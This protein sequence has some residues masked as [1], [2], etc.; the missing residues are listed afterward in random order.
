MNKR[1]GR[2]VPTLLS[3]AILLVLANAATAQEANPP[4]DAQ[5]QTPAATPARAKNLGPVVVTG[6]RAGNRT[7]SSSLTPIDVI[8]ADVLKQT[9]TI[10]LTQALERAIPSLNFPFAPASDTF[11]FQRPF[12][13]RGLSPDQV[14]VLVDGK[15]WHPGALVLS[16]GQIGQGSQGID[17]NTI[18]LSAIDHIEVL[19]DG[20][21]AQYGSDA[22]SGVV[23]IILKKGAKGGDVQLSGG[24]F[25]AGDGRQWQGAANFG[26]PLGGDSGWLRITAEDSNQS[27]SNRAGVDRRPGLAQLGVKFH[28]GTVSF[29]NK[30][31]FLNTQ[32]DITPGVQFYAFGHYGRRVGEPRGFYRYG[33]NTAYPNNPLI[34]LVYPDG[35]LPREHGDSMDTSL[36]AGLRGTWNG[37]RWD[38]SGNYGGNRVSYSTRNSTNYAMLN[39]FGSSPTSFHDGILTAKQQTFDIDISK[40]IAFGWLPNPLTLSFGTQ[41]LRQSY[42]VEAGDFGSYY[43]GT[44]GVRG[45]A[46]GF[47]GWGPQDAISVARHD[48]AEYLQLEGNLTDRFGFSAALRHEDYSDF[49]TTT[50]A[51]LSGRFDFTDSFAL[52]GSAST[53]FR[54]PGLGQQH[55]SETTSAAYGTGNSLGLPPGIYLRGLVPV[56]NPLARLLGS[57]PL[58]A[59]KSRN[60]TAG[61]VWNPTNALNLS[62]DV[63]QI[64]VTNRIALSSS[65]SL[66]TPS[67]VAYLAANGVTNLQYSGLSYFTNAGTVRTQGAD[68]VAS[69]RSDFGDNGSLMSTLSYGYHKNKVT[70]VKPN[71]AVLDS[72]GVIFQ[73]LNRSA[74]KGLLADTA[75]RSKLILNETYS[76][77][78]WAFNGTLTRYGRITSYGST[79]YLD[80]TVYPHKWLLD[81]AASYNHDRWTFTVGSDNVL[82][83]YP[84]KVPED[85]DQNGAFPYSSSSPFGFQ[86]AY[87]YG[88]VQYHW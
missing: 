71:P 25:S 33:S 59:E 49:G 72:L 56:D 88:K 47:A 14:L 57:E 37:W 51:A 86:G 43:V 12:E 73:R 62:L 77:G 48:V 81:L 34:G 11:A 29:K 68:V 31:L 52:R 4:A 58:K 40:E 46:Q 24:Q 28:F 9:G 65:L 53:G 2:I 20:A 54:A 22:L 16:L 36:V 39:D 50:S 61:M 30:N 1:T 7:E 78:N 67:V 66:S 19:R 38:V 79:S 23:N 83:T 3:A 76:L 6:T 13:L 32:Y 44:S 70:D 35:F 63:Y 85:D 45:G 8:S 18:P 5:G 87:V 10:D 64:T 27:P 15:R 60:F 26:I 17:L 74:I 69:Y 42:D 82:N 21:S 55:Y 75:P 80:D 41:Y 84:K